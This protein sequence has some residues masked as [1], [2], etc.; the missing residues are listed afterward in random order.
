M[1]EGWND[2]YRS[3]DDAYKVNERMGVE[4]F[5]FYR[6]FPL[7]SG[8]A[9][10]S[11]AS[12]ARIRNPVK[13]GLDNCVF[14]RFF[15][16]LPCS[17]G[18]GFQ[19]STTLIRSHYGDQRLCVCTRVTT[20]SGVCFNWVAAK[21]ACGRLCRLFWLI[22]TVVYAC[23]FFAVELDGCKICLNQIKG[24]KIARESWCLLQYP[25][26]HLWVE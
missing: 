13:E 5:F 4:A 7:A 20:M 19:C 6:V 1:G 24:E 8:L 16:L 3:D 14:D 12:S 17:F 25:C 2:P 18:E 11:L 26:V 21:W 10:P 15:F 23:L 22:S 9:I